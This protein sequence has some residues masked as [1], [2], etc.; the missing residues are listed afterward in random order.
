MNTSYHEY[1][2]YLHDNFVYFGGRSWDGKGIVMPLYHDGSSSNWHTYRNVE[3]FT[4]YYTVYA[5][6]YLQNIVTERVHNVLVENNEIIGTYKGYEDYSNR[7]D[8][9]PKEFEYAFFGTDYNR[10]IPAELRVDEYTYYSRVDDTRNLVQRHNYLYDSPLDI[11]SWAGHVAG[12][13]DETGSTMQKPVSDDILEEIQPLYDE[14]WEEK[15]EE[16]MES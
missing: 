1:F 15:E 7:D 13:I 3:L 11:L 14:W 12:M 9:D 10:P 2:N 4:P 5:G 8:M 6:I 16:W